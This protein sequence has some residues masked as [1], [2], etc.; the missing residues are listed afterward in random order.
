MPISVLVLST[1]LLIA[2]AGTWFATRQAHGPVR[3]SARTVSVVTLLA[4][5]L[6]FLG[7]LTAAYEGGRPFGLEVLR[8]P[9]SLWVDRFENP[10]RPLVEIACAS[11]DCRQPKNRG[12]YS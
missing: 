5:A 2:G 3:R 9:Y 8:Y 12:A 11:A 4:G 10:T 7:A 1:I 6:V